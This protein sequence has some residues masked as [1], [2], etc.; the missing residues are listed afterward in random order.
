MSTFSGSGL[1][2]NQNNW[3]FVQPYVLHYSQSVNV[4]TTLLY[5]LLP[6]YLAH[7]ESKSKILF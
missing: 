4:F 5:T 7:T 3:L 1:A 6:R 2:S